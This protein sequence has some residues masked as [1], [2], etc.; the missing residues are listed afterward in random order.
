[1][2][3]EV[4]DGFVEALRKLDEE[5]IVEALVEKEHIYYDLIAA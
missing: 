4:G 3:S 2:S 1:M 5:E